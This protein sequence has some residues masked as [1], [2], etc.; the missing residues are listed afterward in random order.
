MAAIPLC[1]PF[2]RKDEAR[3]A[4]ARW[5]ATQRVWTCEVA[6]LSTDAYA[7]LRPFVPRIYRPDL[8]PP[9]I[10]PWMVPQTVWGKNLRALL[11][12]HEWDVVR[13]AAY[14]ASG[15][16]CRVCGERGP[17]WPVEADE[18]RD[19]DDETR[20]QTLKGVIALCPDC[21]HIRHWGKTMIDGHEEQ[22]F[23]LLM[24]L[25]RWTRAQAEEAV[26][27]ALDQWERRSRHEWE[28][29]YS[30]VT[31]VHGFRPEAEGERRVEAA[32]RE[33]VGKAAERARLVER[34][35]ESRR[36]SAEWPA[37]ARPESMIRV[38]RLTPSSILGYLQKLTNR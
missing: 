17:Q 33:L 4:G 27:F 36:F 22:A 15:N 19:Y 16:R 7:H 34:E 2:E 18:G 20:T 23:A 12:Q 3:R 11:P 21:H 26:A 1:V 9:Y 30:W 5:D 38:R 13:K 28:S 29:D 31:R 24:S 10:R 25:N 6:L 32:N 8:S 37:Q 14:A 35:T